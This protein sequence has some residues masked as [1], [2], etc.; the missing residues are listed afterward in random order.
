MGVCCEC[1]GLS[2][3]V[4]LIAGFRFEVKSEVKGGGFFIYQTKI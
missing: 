3:V 4:I 1:C 2:D